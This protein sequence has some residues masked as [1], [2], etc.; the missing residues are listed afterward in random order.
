MG[1]KGK[2]C[3]VV[4]TLGV[5]GMERVASLLMNHANILAYDVHLVCL[6]GEEVGFC[7]NP[8][9]VVHKPKFKYK[10]GL[11]GKLKVFLY[12]TK[13]LRSVRPD[14][15]LSFSEVFN[16]LSIIC[17]RIA[18]VPIFIS[19]RSN[20]Y[21]NHRSTIR[22]LRRLI[23]P[24]SRGMISQTN[25]AKNLAIQR[26]Y[27]KNITVIPNPLRDVVDSPS[28]KKEKVVVSV[29]RLVPSKNFLSLIDIFLTADVS[30]SWELWILGE[31]P[32]R[33]KIEEKIK[34]LKVSSRVKLKGS[35]ENVDYFLSKSSI[36]AYASVSEGFPNALSEALASPLPCVAYDCPVG[37]S[38]LIINN[39]NGYLVPLHNDVGFVECLRRLMSDES[40]R[41]RFTMEY[42]KHRKRYH[43]E[44]ICKKYLDFILKY[45]KKTIR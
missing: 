27:N 44:N 25:T 38:D 41:E 23:Y 31:G 21:I 24:L 35:V 42:L 26:K 43:A 16:P 6:I 32:E 28:I 40:E 30:N 2:I 19:D 11:L 34:M 33:E 15:V 1:S 8:T 10:K 17:A 20:P 45:V 9:I 37:P 36:F 18:Q 29:G 39:V 4:P 13:I 22:V 12:L 7:L 5:G 14:T 3:I